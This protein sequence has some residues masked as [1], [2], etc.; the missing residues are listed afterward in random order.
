MPDVINQEEN[1][2]KKVTHTLVKH[3]AV[4]STHSNG[5]N[6]ELNLISWNG[7]DPKYDIRDWSPDHQ[8]MSKGTTLTQDELDALCEAA[9][10]L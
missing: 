4:L 3:I 2:Q 9:K 6:K 5:W 8:K 10:N 1:N 7:F